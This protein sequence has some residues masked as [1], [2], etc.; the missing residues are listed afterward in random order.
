MI[1]YVLHKIYYLSD[2]LGL[3]FS[4]IIENLFKNRFADFGFWT[5]KLKYIEIL[6]LKSQINSLFRFFKNKTGIM[7][8]CTDMKY[9][10]L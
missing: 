6:S 10:K 4:K 7:E 9:N 5:K 1:L 3:I 2:L 8:N